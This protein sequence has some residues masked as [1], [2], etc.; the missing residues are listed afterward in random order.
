LPAVGADAGLDGLTNVNDVWW[1]TLSAGTT[2]RIAFSSDGCAE[3]LMRSH[4]G[5]VRYFECNGYTTFTPAPDAA[6]R[7]LFEVTAP[8]RNG[9]TRYRLRIAAATRDDVGVGLELA[10]LKTV[11]GA[12]SPIAGDVVDLYHFDVQRRSDVRVRLESPGAFSLTLVTFDGR[13][14]GSSSR[15][16][17]RDLGSG[18]Y[19]VAV[20]APTDSRAGPYGLSLVIRDVTTTRLKLSATEVAP[21]VSVVFGVAVTPTTAGGSIRLEIDRFDPLSGWQFNRAITLRSPT[22]SYRWTPPAPGR[23]RVSARYRGTLRSSPSG[24][25]NSVIL[26]ARPLKSGTVVRG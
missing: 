22:A 10:N 16:I 17:D 23:W 14:L 2:Y 24:T 12:L 21:G 3:L 4:R 5:D 13:V 6:G 18:H 11:R 19:V 25:G 7:Y 9:S 8:Q 1:A 26:V 15:A 20:R